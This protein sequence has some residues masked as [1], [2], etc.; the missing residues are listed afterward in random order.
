[1]GMTN[2]FAAYRHFDPEINRSKLRY[3]YRV[4]V[5]ESATGEMLKQ[6]QHDNIF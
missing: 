6:V 3:E 5:S 4:T 1:M 2:T